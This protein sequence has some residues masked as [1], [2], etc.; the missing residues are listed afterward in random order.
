MS[1]IHQKV[2]GTSPQ[3]HCEPKAKQSLQFTERLP[4]R[5]FGAPRNDKTQKYLLPLVIAFTCLFASTAFAV[6]TPED[7]KQ[8]MKEVR[9]DFK[10]GTSLPLTLPFL[11]EKGETVTLGN[12]FQSKPVVILPVYYKCPMLCTL[13]LNEWIQVLRVLG[14]AP[15]RDFDIVTYSIDPREKFDLAASKKANYAK[16]IPSLDV[17]NGWHF[18]TGDENSIKALSDAIGF[19]YKY[20]EKTDQYAHPAAVM[21]ASKDGVLTHYFSGIG[22]KPMDVRLGI[23]DASKG[24]IG[25]AIDQ[26]LLL[27]YHYDPI[28]GKYG[29]VIKR[30]IQAAGILT[31]TG[32]GLLLVW[33]IRK[34]K[35]RRAS[36]KT[37]GAMN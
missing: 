12:Y 9:V 6:T 35:K 15:G 25:S 5:P 20:E 34:D 4:R 23:V 17:A 26:I 11:N 37:T 22:M 7:P 29:L 33:M 13:I 3:C 28:T 21:V 31:M 14:L 27:C 19:Y 8:I 32:M 18:L 24:K 10:R 36:Q 16:E 30:A 2:P 1:S